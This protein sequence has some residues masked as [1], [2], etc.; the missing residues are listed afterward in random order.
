MW[1]IDSFILSPL[2]TFGFWLTGYHFD[3]MLHSVMFCN[4]KSIDVNKKN[5]G[6]HLSSEGRT[7]IET[8][9]RWGE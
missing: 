7:H 8:Q 4:L 9:V 3:I 5:R 1:M 6:V 2:V